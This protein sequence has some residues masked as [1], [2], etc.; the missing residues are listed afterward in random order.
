MDDS[1]SRGVF[2]LFLI[3]MASYLYKTVQCWILLYGEFLTSTKLSCIIL[4]LRPKHINR[5]L[6]YYRQ[7]NIL[8]VMT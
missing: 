2:C 1:F 3:G 4:F 8:S 7:Q 6:L 5:I